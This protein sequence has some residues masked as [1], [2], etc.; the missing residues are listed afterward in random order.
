MHSSKK[1]NIKYKYKYEKVKQMFK[2]F[3]QNN[4]HYMKNNIN[5]ICYV[6]LSSTVFNSIRIRCSYFNH[7]SIVTLLSKWLFHAY[8]DAIKGFKSS[9]TMQKHF[10]KCS[11][12]LNCSCIISIPIVCLKFIQIPHCTNDCLKFF[13]LEMKILCSQSLTDFKLTWTSFQKIKL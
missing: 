8:I 5:W 1:W 9:V 7:L 4:E 10:E 13:Q 2:K 3:I 11:D 12:H 6:R